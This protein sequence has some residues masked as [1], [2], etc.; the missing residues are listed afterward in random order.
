[1]RKVLLAAVAT[2]FL[3][4]PFAASADEV[5]IR[6]H[7]NGNVTIREHAAPAPRVREDRRLYDRAAPGAVIEERVGPRQDGLTI[8]DR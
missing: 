7:P 3:S 5:N 2:V 6:D 4:A 8:R 1:M